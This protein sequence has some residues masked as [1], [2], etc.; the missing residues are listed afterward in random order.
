MADPQT[1]GSWNLDDIDFD[2]YGRVVIKNEELA[3]RLVDTIAEYGGLSLRFVEPVLPPQVTQPAT[4]VLRKC[5]PV[6]LKTCPNSG[7]LS[8]VD[9]VVPL[10]QFFSFAPEEPTDG[11]PESSTSP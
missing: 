2:E 4:L 8:G 7:C 6:P 9:L 11:A 10:N 1:D 5:P 3:Q